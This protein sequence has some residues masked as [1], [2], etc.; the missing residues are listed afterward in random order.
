MSQAQTPSEKFGERPQDK[1]LKTAPTI[2]TMENLDE[3]R[4]IMQTFNKE[5]IDLIM[6]VI[7]A[8]QYASFTQFLGAM[9]DFYVVPD[10]PDKNIHIAP[11]VNRMFQFFNGFSKE[12]KT[13]LTA[14]NG[15]FVEA[16]IRA[17]ESI[18]SSEIK[19]HDNE[20]SKGWARKTFLGNH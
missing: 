11:E 13:A 4:V 1:A 6:P 16:V 18:K 10:N 3:F 17:L 15:Y 12:Y 8:D 20:P 7:S 14:E 5:N 2:K 19:G 9:Q